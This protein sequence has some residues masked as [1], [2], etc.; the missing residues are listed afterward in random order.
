[1][2]TLP[3][4]QQNCCSFFCQRLTNC[5]SSFCQR[6]HSDTEL[7]I[8]D[9]HFV[10]QPDVNTPKQELAHWLDKEPG[11]NWRSQQSNQ[12]WCNN[13]PKVPLA[14]SHQLIATIFPW[15]PCKNHFSHFLHFPVKLVVNNQPLGP[16]DQA[17]WVTQFSCCF[18]WCPH[19]H[20]P[21]WCHEV[22]RHLQSYE[23]LGLVAKGGCCCC[24]CCLGFSFSAAASTEF[25]LGLS[26]HPPLWGTLSLISTTS[27]VIPWCW[28]CGQAP[29]RLVWQERSQ[30]CLW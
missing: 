20:P 15:M 12:N 17:W 22:W 14:C 26:V 18:C 27:R 9:K 24:C 5:F 13:L 11:P 7:W 1:M 30:L 21:Q 4:L 10:G 2:R 23:R 8:C 19:V 28:H 6:C 29:L 25:S 16:A 3:H